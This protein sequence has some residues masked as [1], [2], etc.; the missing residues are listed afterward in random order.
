VTLFDPNRGRIPPPNLDDRVW[1]DIV[2]ES[3]SLIP[4]YAPQWTDHGPSD[5]GITLIELFAWMVE[6]LTYRLNQVPEKNYLAFLDL[7]GIKR[8]PPEPARAFLTF[9]A[10]PNP[11]IVAKGRQAQTA[12]SETE[13][14]IIF[15]TD[16]DVTVLPINLKVALQIGKVVFN[17]YTNVST[18]FTVPPAKGE[19]INIAVGQSVQLC[20]GFDAA[21]AQ[22]IDLMI[23][24]FAPLQA[25]QATVTWLYSSGA[26][27]PSA[28]T[29][30]AVPPASDGTNG[31]QQDGIIELNV[32]VNWGNQAPPTWAS[33]APASAADTVP[34]A[35]FWI[36][37]RIANL[38]AQPLP[39]GFNWILFNA[40]SSHSALT[41]PAPEALGN[42]TGT[43]FQVVPLANGS[44]FERPD[45][46]TPYDHLVVTVGGA[47]WA[48]VEEFPD[49]PGNV[50][51]VDPIASEISFG[52]FDPLQ[53]V[54]HG[55]MP[56][57]AQAIV[58]VTYRYVEAGLAANVG[59]GTIVAMR[60]P[61]AGIVGVTN[62]FA[63]Y[64]G[65]DQEPIEDAKRRA[66]ELLRNRNR[67]VTKED[68]EFLARESSTEL[69]A[70]RCLEPYIDPATKTAWQFGGLDRSAGNV[71]VIIVPAQGP[72]I[73][74]TPQPTPELVHEVVRYLD[75][76][77][78]V[79][80]R[81][82]VAGPRYLPVDVT[83]AASAWQKA[84]DAGLILGAN[85]VKVGIENRIKQFF[86]PVVGGLNAKGWQVGQN[87]FIAD[88]YKAIMPSEDLGFISTLQIQGGTPLYTP[89]ARPFAPSP[90]GAWVRL[91]D[92]ELVCMGA[93]NWLAPVTAV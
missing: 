19:T 57:P 62:L 54:G 63:A 17:K 80:A 24:L 73:S 50:Y 51:R 34:N 46:D 69:A 84:I 18:A 15:E 65:A 83:I 6:G 75:R 88:L 35:Y 49:G 48:Q 78:D 60:T 1:A 9:S 77:R 27:A 76:R 59:A 58:A 28:W 14:P 5:I 87:A 7:L 38:T 8:D 33:V 36:G 16:Q 32:P 20:L 3:V 30:L 11:V 56:G 79:T 61:V 37:L 71:H 43:P 47:T 64:G 13:A 12:G 26:L 21:S 81:L 29:S 23:R 22:P 72:A 70:V 39:I 66:P 42:G 90:L 86:H 91:A 31:L 92:Y 82:H 55:S 67:A 25:G 10:T 2:N 45:T 53:S 89:P 44:L 40:V 41:I 68:Y 74:Q 93:I 4:K 52:N 85:D